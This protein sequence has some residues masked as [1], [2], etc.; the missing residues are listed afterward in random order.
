MFIKMLVTCLILFVSMPQ[1]IT[2]TST[3]TTNNQVQ[4]VEK[5][6][7][8]V[9]EE[10]QS[11]IYYTINTDT[12]DTIKEETENIIETIENP[13]FKILNNILIENQ[14][15]REDVLFNDFVVKDDIGYLDMT[16]VIDY[17]GSGFESATLEAI[18]NT[19]IDNYNLKDFRLTVNNE[20]YASGHIILE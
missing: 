1:I 9:V 13:K 11:Y 14:I 17:L 12:Y 18:K 4:V 2:D 10:T 15:I 7:T 19:F 8:Q 20:P 5:I 3:L 16:K 6:E